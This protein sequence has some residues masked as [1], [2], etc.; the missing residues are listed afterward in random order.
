MSI[1]R[2]ALFL[3]RLLKAKDDSVTLNKIEKGLRLLTSKPQRESSFQELKV[4]DPTVFSSLKRISD[5]LSTI[6]ELA[7]TIT[8]PD[9]P[10]ETVN[11]LERLVDD[12]LYHI[13]EWDHF[14]NQ[15]A[16]VG[17]IGKLG[18]SFSGGG[19]V[20][21]VAAERRHMGIITVP[22]T[23]VSGN[24]TALFLGGVA[25]DT[26][27]NSDDI[28]RMQFIVRLGATITAML[29]RAG[30]MLNL[31]T[32][33]VNG[34]YFE[35]TAASGVW[36]AVTQAAGVETRTAGKTA[37]ASQWEKLEFFIRDDGQVDFFVGDVLF[38][39]HSTNIPSNTA[40]N[41]GIATEVTSNNIR[42]ADIDY[43]RMTS[44][45]YPYNEMFT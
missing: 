33:N 26:V 44:P 16:E 13:D 29:F 21:N 1:R 3:Q 6:E 14:I 27:V 12:P 10:D 17:E 7:R 28:Q 20:G 5:D 11:V 38:A 35:Y 45:L 40:L 25:G 24:I 18:W 34:I 32:S 22:S 42:S 23:N 2:Q 4:K 30:M 31:A 19:A 39:S 41:I 43:F 37:V 36:N 15:G 8:D 9:V